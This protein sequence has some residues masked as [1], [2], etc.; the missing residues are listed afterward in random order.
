MWVIRYYMNEMQTPR[1]YTYVTMQYIQ[2]SPPPLPHMLCKSVT[3][4]SF[5]SVSRH[6]LLFPRLQL[7][8]HTTAPGRGVEERKPSPS[9]GDYERGTI[10]RHILQRITANA[11]ADKREKISLSVYILYIRNLL[12]SSLSIPCI[13]FLVTKSLRMQQPPQQ[14]TGA[15]SSALCSGCRR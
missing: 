3:I 6:S 13:I 1:L 8:N 5:S 9:S 10:P 11:A 7:Y 12:Y 14:Y 2:Y 4:P 15:R